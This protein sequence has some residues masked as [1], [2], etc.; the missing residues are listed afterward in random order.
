MKFYLVSDD[1][2]AASLI[3]SAILDRGLEFPAGNQ[4][5]LAGVPGLIRTLSQTAATESR[6]GSGAEQQSTILLDRKSTRL[7]SSHT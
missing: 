7:N 5:R 4:C 3:R 2:T 1:E 6:Q